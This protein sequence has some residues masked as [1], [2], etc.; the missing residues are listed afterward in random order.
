MF[1]P[2]TVLATF[3]VSSAT[4]CIIEEWKEVLG[5]L[6]DGASNVCGLIDNQA[7][8]RKM[9]GSHLFWFHFYATGWL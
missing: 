1:F 9:K 7:C 4:L 8:N 2:S 6:L 3:V 5:F